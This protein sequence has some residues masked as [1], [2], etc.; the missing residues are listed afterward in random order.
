MGKY[1]SPEPERGSRLRW[2][3]DTLTRAN[4]QQ[5]GQEGVTIAAI[6]LFGKDSTI[7][8]VFPQH[9]TDAIFR[10][11]CWHTETFRVVM[12]PKWLSKKIGY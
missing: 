10:V 9:K 5:E 11:F 3:M 8:S 7:M 6:L 1:I 12:W 4:L 2:F